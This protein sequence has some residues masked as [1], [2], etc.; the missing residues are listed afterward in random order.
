MEKIIKVKEDYNSLEKLIDFLKTESPFDISKDYDHWDVRT[1]SN[2]QM[3]QCVVIKKSNM[4]GAKAYFEDENTLK[5]DYIIPNK[6]MNAYFGKSVKAR[7][8]II[9]ILAETIKNTALAG[10]QKKTFEEITN[11]FNKISV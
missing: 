4:H 3:E 1:D 7:K 6:M 8:N 2:G 11:S 10:S 9:E 5:I